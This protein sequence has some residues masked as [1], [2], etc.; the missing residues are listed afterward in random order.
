MIVGGISC[1]YLDLENSRNSDILLKTPLQMFPL[2]VT[3]DNCHKG[4]LVIQFNE[5]NDQEMEEPPSV[6]INQIYCTN[7]LMFNMILGNK[8]YNSE[9]DVP[10]QKVQTAIN[11]PNE[12]KSTSSNEN[13]LL[14]HTTSPCAST[15]YEN[16]VA[17]RTNVCNEYIIKETDNESVFD[18]DNHTLTDALC[19][20]LQVNATANISDLKLFKVIGSQVS[21]LNSRVLSVAIDDISETSLCLLGTKCVLNNLTYLVIYFSTLVDIYCHIY[22]SLQALSEALTESQILKINAIP[23]EFHQDRFYDLYQCLKEEDSSLDISDEKKCILDIRSL[24]SKY[25]F[26]GFKIETTP[27]TNH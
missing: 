7:L 8:D 25:M 10:R 17:K 12:L 1:G 22:S 18:I 16:T 5:C 4:S 19:C 2:N 6:K 14:I 9:Q 21:L 11:T 3:V 27:K 20:S 15:S 13:R 24:L 23:E 26:H